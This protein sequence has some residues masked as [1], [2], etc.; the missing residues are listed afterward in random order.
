MSTLTFRLTDKKLHVYGITECNME[1]FHCYSWYKG[2][3]GATVFYCS[4]IYT[5]FGILRE[6]DIIKPDW[7]SI[8]AEVM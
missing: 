3:D 2:S 5:L 1:R 6:F 8:E 4:D 7:K